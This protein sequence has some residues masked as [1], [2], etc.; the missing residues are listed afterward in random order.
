M[1]GFLAGVAVV[2]PNSIKTLLGNGLITFFMKGKRVFSNGPK[3]LST[4]PP[5]CPI[6]Y[7]WIFDNF[8]LCD[9]LFAKALRSLET[10][11]LVNNSLCGKL[12]SSLKL[13]ITF[14]ERSKV[15][16]I[17]FFIPVAKLIKLRIRQFD[18]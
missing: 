11:V 13:L 17:P 14:N 6:L 15:I 12:Y 9:E 1:A 2:D 8:I 10:F 3:S 5:D 16:S 4:N 7:N 18:V